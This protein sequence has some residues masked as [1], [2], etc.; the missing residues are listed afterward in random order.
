MKRDV[1]VRPQRNARGRVQEHR[2]VLFTISA[3]TAFL[4]AMLFCPLPVVI[5][6]GKYPFYLSY[7]VW[8]I[9]ILSVPTA[10]R[11]K[12]YHTSLTAFV[13]IL[14]W[15]MSFGFL[16]VS[17]QV[18]SVELED[19]ISW[20]GTLAPT[21][22]YEVG[23]LV[24]ASDRHWM[25]L[26]ILLLVS[27][28]SVLP[29]SIEAGIDLIRGGTQGLLDSARNLRQVNASWPNY[30]AIMMAICFLIAREVA[31]VQRGYRV[32]L[33]VPLFILGLTLSRTGIIALLC[34]LFVTLGRSRG[35]GF[36]GRIMVSVLSL[37]VAWIVFI[38]KGATPGS[39][40]SY[41]I[42][43][44]IERWLQAI[45]VWADNPL[46]GTGFR[47]FT[48]A[49]PSYYS[50]F[51]GR[52]LDAGSAHNDF[53]DLLVRGGVMYLS[54]F[55]L[56]VITY[57]VHCWHKTLHRPDGLGRLTLAVPAVIL[58]AAI[59]QNPL[60]DPSIGPLFWLFVGMGAS[61]E[62]RMLRY[63]NSSYG[64]REDLHS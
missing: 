40:L 52:V 41:T 55:L 53:I 17:L 46:F 3:L 16:I 20:I 7:L 10:I 19:V 37:G 62:S 31:T 32:L 9:A 56:F 22:F 11:V 34:G 23:C 51:S 60:K 4:T 27:L 35:R 59:V 26:K 18:Q 38:D 39:M 49:V 25:L 33:I 13:W 44:R 58:S 64:S 63:L 21:F 42:G 50:V 6:R 61:F 2:L 8:L 24:V 30:V 14:R 54:I 43:A 36:W 45:R 48:A 15:G 1:I 47:S 28:L 29:V 12:G 5:V 57:L